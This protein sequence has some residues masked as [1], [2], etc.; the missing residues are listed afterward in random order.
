MKKEG[1]KIVFSTENYNHLEKICNRYYK[2]SNLSVIGLTTDSYIYNSKVIENGDLSYFLST[3]GITSVIFCDE[4]N[5]DSDGFK[6]PEYILKLREKGFDLEKCLL[7][8]L[9]CGINTDG[10][11]L[12][13][14]ISENCPEIAVSGGVVTAKGE[15]QPVIYCNGKL[16]NEGAVGILL[17]EEKLKILQSYLFDWEEIGDYHL[18]THSENNRVYEIDGIP[19]V[20]F[21]GEILGKEVENSLPDVGIEYPLVI[22]KGNKRIARA[23]IKKLPDNSLIFAGHVPEGT[24]VR[25]SAGNL[26]GF[27]PHSEEIKELSTVAN[28]SELVFIFSCIARKKFLKDL[29]EKELQIF[30]NV[31]NIGFF[32]HGEYFKKHNE[33]GLLLNETLTVSG[34]ATD[35]RSNPVYT[36]KENQLYPFSSMP[37]DYIP[38]FHML[39]KMSRESHILKEGISVTNSCM[40][41]LEKEQKYGWICT[42]VSDNIKDILGLDKT[43]VKS[44]KIN[45]NILL[46]TIVF[47]EDRERF[48]RAYQKVLKQGE[49]DIDYRIVKNGTVRW[50]NSFVKLMKNKDFE[51]LIHV[52]QDITSDKEIELMAEC[53]PLTGLFNRRIIEEIGNELKLKPKPINSWN[54]IMFIDI[55]KFKNI[56]DTYGHEIGDKVLSFV[57]NCIEKSIR[58]GNDIA[59]RYA[60]DEFIILLLNTKSSKEE[61]IKK[62]RIVADRILSEV[63]KSKDKPYLPTIGISIGI[64][65]FRGIKN[66]KSAIASADKA[67]YKAKKSGG[68]RYEIDRR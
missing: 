37:K 40:I 32:T 5:P 58:K 12:I 48:K 26:R 39:K 30:R 66:L 68:N 7:I 47:P 34:I 19:V 63:K 6:L 46:E 25:F 16:I 23:C 4:R 11:L 20:E 24:E 43:S 57:A 52:H 65:A 27:S 53:D 55:D 35:E 36:V 54:A 29:A 50:I 8:L 62:A 60:G 31:P 51:T 28:K 64:K 9:S 14:S 22:N 17:C 1:I 38:I 61:T 49:A 59:I 18:V 67:M 10:E 45:A 15:N 42:F 2:N 3:S 41:I 44:K 13:K 56:N 33:D 21:Y